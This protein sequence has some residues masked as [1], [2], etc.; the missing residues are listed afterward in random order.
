MKSLT[1]IGILLLAGAAY[2]WQWLY[3]RG[4][5]SR[6]PIEIPIH[7]TEGASVPT[8][9]VGAE[10]DHHIEIECPA[11]ASNHVR[12]NLER[13]TGNASLSSGGVVL[14]HATLPVRHGT[15]ANGRHA[16]ILFTVPTKPRAEYELFLDM[17]EI[18]A[19]LATSQG[20]LKVELDPHYNLIFPQ[21]EFI[22]VLLVVLALFCLLPAIRRQAQRLSSKKVRAR[23]H[24]INELVL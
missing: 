4:A 11:D 3:S 18:P 9:F 5:F 15:Y 12:R 13:I 8:R 20:R 6:A 10:N 23:G 21:I 24:L 2:C 19:D 22:G 16:I 17:T 14:A 1:L 7:L